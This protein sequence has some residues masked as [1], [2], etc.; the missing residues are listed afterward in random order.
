MYLDIGSLETFSIHMDAFA[1]LQGN[2]GVDDSLG[3]YC[4]YWY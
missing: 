1:V 4:W 2:R 3:K